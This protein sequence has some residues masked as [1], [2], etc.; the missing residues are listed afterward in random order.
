MPPARRGKPNKVIAT[1]NRVAQVVD[2]YIGEPAKNL[3]RVFDTVEGA[4][5]C[6]PSTRRMGCSGGERTETI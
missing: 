1:A 5:R 3:V 2:E 4:K 6:C